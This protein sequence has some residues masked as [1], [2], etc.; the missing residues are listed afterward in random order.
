MEFFKQLQPET[1][2]NDEPPIR[3]KTGCDAAAPASR[4]CLRREDCAFQLSVMVLP[5][6]RDSSAAKA[7]KWPISEI[8]GPEQ[9]SEGSLA[10]IAS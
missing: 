1:A 5:V 2:K 7:I 3:K 10:V 4:F 6:T 8:S 9:S